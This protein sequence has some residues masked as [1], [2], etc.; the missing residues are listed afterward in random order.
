MVVE[1]REHEHEVEDD[2]IL[3]DPN[4]II[5]LRNCGFLKFFEVP[6]MKAKINYSEN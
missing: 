1:W 2:A 6:N 3:L 4:V 5:A